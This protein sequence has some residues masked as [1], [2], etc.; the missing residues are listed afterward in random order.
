[1]FFRH[2]VHSSLHHIVIKSNHI[3]LRDTFIMFVRER[4]SC[5]DIMDQRIYSYCENTAIRT[6]NWFE[7]QQ[8]GKTLIHVYVR[9]L[10]LFLNLS[11]MPIMTFHFVSHTRKIIR[12]SS[13]SGWYTNYYEKFLFLLNETIIPNHSPYMTLQV[14]VRW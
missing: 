4:F 7:K 10:L 13:V 14:P 3:S 11:M 2:F 8:L 9:L 1:M 5:T 6:L 12:F